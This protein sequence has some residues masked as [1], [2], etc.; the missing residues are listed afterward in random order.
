VKDTY[1]ALLKA[2]ANLITRAATKRRHP[3]TLRTHSPE[4]VWFVAEVLGNHYRS[5]RT[6][7]LQAM[8]RR[9]RVSS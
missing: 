3:S 7:T 4:L 8:A 2:H 5:Q 1:Q 6:V 9:N